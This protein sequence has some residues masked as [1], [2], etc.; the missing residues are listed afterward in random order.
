MHRRSLL[1]TTL[2]IATVLAACAPGVVA[3]AVREAPDA[4]TPG[5]SFEVSVVGFSGTLGV[6]LC[7]LTVA[8]DE[9][10]A[11]GGV[12]VLT[13]TVPV[14]PGGTCDLV[15]TT[16]EASVTVEVDVVELLSGLSVGYF[17]DDDGRDDEY[18]FTAY[19]EGLAAT[20][21]FD[22]TLYEGDPAFADFIADVA[23]ETAPDVMF[24]SVSGGTLVEAIWTE[25]EA[26]LEAA[27]GVAVILT[28]CSIS[29]ETSVGVAWGIDVDIAECYGDDEVA[30]FDIAPSLTAGDDAPLE[31]TMGT[32]S[33]NYAFT[34]TGVED[35]VEVFCTDAADPDAVCG[36]Y[37]RTY[38]A[39]LAGWV[40]EAM[41]G[42]QGDELLLQLARSLF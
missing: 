2:A 33:W 30:S 39:A 34:T 5:Q 9:T 4:V 37:H 36:V 25:I 26:Y 14:L 29:D 21:L 7:G 12:T 1:L 42:G 40:P 3:P 27:Q 13:G 28:Y 16:A 18:R 17:V 8:I 15:V 32:F 20:D 23:A 11:P 10:D 24:F 31:L 41:V 6:E 35:D 22:L 38:P 19:L